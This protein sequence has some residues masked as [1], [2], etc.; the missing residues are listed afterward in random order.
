MSQNILLAFRVDLHLKV[1][2]GFGPEIWVTVLLATGLVVIGQ[3]LALVMTAMPVVGQAASA[4]VG[5]YGWFTA[6]HLIGSF[7]R[8][9]ASRLSEV[10]EAWR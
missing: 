7:F 10:Y 4:A 9:Y 3:V 6:A 1:L 2:A 5:M 8:R